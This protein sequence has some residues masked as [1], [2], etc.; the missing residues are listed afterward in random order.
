MN[1]VVSSSFVFEAPLIKNEFIL[2]HY[3][4]LNNNQHGCH[5]YNFARMFFTNHIT[6]SVHGVALR[7]SKEGLKDITESLYL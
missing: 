6:S 1:S 3:D 2:I 5:A 4:S 7:N